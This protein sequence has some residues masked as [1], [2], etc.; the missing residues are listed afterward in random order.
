MEVTP[1]IIIPLLFAT[2]RRYPL[3]FYILVFHAIILMVGGMYTYAKVP[4][5]FQVQDARA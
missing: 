3:T 1:V 5:G 4:V 2:H